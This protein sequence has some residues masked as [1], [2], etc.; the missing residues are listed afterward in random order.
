MAR[1]E[2][3]PAQVRVN[4]IFAECWL[5]VGIPLPNVA[6]KCLEKVDKGFAGINIKVRVINSEY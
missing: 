1:E 5:L 3:R 2:M 6:E 4:E